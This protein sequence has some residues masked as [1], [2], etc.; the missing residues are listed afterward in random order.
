MILKS[1][2]DDDNGSHWGELSSP[3]PPANPADGNAIAPASTMDEDRSIR[4]HNKMLINTRVYA[5]SD[6][7]NV[8]DLKP[9][10]EAQFNKARSLGSWPHHRFSTIV[11]EILRSTPASDKGLREVALGLC[12]E[13][14]LELLDDTT[15]GD[16]EHDQWEMVLRDDV[17]FLFD[18]LRA[19]SRART[20][21]LEARNVQQGDWQAKYYLV[22]KELRELRDLSN[23]KA[24]ALDRL[25]TKLRCNNCRGC[26]AVFQPTITKISAG[27]GF[28]VSCRSCGFSLT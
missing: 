18:V 10:A 3:Q 5:I 13:H 7:F 16:T 2:Q 8:L 21:E 25:L 26:R 15:T 17:T 1:K 23:I 27:E 22:S 20:K 9:L 19:R 12:S 4:I 6:K 14:V 24:T 11:A 28:Q